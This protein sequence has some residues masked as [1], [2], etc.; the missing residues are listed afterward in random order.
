MKSAP[1]NLE[2]NYRSDHLPPKALAATIKDLVNKEPNGFKEAIKL[3]KW[4][5]AMQ[6]VYEALISNKN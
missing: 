1:I 5:K 4:C 3:E 2:Q 6:E